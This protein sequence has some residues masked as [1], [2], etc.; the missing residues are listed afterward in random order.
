MS[1][2]TTSR[3][4]GDN[5]F[6]VLLRLPDLNATAWLPVPAA[7]STIAAVAPP[8]LAPAPSSWTA[9]VEIPSIS[10]PDPVLATTSIDVAANTATP[11]DTQATSTTTVTAP[12]RSERISRAE[13][14]PP[15]Q[16][17]L[18]RQLATGGVLVGG[19]ALTYFMIMGSGDDDTPEHIATAETTLEP[20]LIETP[21]NVVAM[22]NGAHASGTT[23]H[24]HEVESPA[25]DITSVGPPPDFSREFGTPPAMPSHIEVAEI[26]QRNNVP[27]PPVNS[28]P[29]DTQN[30]S[31]STTDRDNV[32]QFR[33]R[34]GPA[35]QSAVVPSYPNYP[36][37][38]PATF[39]Y[40]PGTGDAGSEAARTAR[41]NGTI[42]PPPL[43]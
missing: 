38:D 6:P 22:T 23:V 39:L 1:T 21:T 3:P 43:R 14:T 29:Q 8:E 13:R 34:V 2:A 17:T 10:L 37:T 36:T 30:T 15:A 25:N 32:G 42:A 12:P 33:G 41:L 5:E 35:T 24:K 9:P 40:R 26:P 31:P 16:W 7:A 11:A 4:V 20:P 27:A 18:I 19:L 28:S